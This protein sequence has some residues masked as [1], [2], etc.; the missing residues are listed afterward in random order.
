M[1]GRYGNES[2]RLKRQKQ[3]RNPDNE[4]I[5]KPADI[6]CVCGKKIFVSPKDAVRALRSLWRHEDCTGMETYICDLSGYYH[7]GHASENIRIAND[8][9]ARE[10]MG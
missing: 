4:W 5:E 1:A 2:K 9:K 7:L 6:R 3:N 8:K 10:E